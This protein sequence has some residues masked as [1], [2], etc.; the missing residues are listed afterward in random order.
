MKNAKIGDSMAVRH[1]ESN[2]SIGELNLQM[3]PPQIQVKAIQCYT[4][5]MRIPCWEL[6]ILQVVRYFVLFK[7]ECSLVRELERG[8]TPVTE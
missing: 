8:E 5:C 6:I 3:A 7:N 1:T 2:S 4:H